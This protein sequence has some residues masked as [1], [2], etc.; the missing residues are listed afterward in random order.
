MDVAQKVS[1]FIYLLF[2]NVFNAEMPEWPNGADSRAVTR[3]AQ[4]TQ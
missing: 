1:T 3:L 2:L 4:A